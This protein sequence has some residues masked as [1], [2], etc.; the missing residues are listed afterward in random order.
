MSAM[1]AMGDPSVPVS[2]APMS[3]DEP[4]HPLGVPSG[5]LDP[6]QTSSQEPTGRISSRL[7]AQSHCVGSLKPTTAAVFTPQN[8]ANA[9]NPF[10][11][12]KRA[13]WM[14]P[15]PQPASDSHPLSSLETV[16]RGKGSLSLA[17]R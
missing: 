10:C 3:P 16:A 12:F 4:G 1:S 8:L 14:L 17:P 11:F 13:N 7:P 5:V 6:A 2:P 9:T 15:I